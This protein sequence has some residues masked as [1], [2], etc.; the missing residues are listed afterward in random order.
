VATQ[1]ITLAKI[2]G[3]AAEVVVRRLR[4]WSAARRTDLGDE[5][6]NEQWPP[7]VRRQADEFTERLRSHALAAPVI[8]FIEWV[9]PWSMGDLFAHWLTPSEG[10]PPSVVH[11]DRFEL[12]GYALPDDGR[13][14]RYLASAGLQQFKESDWYVRRLQEAVES[15]SGVTDR[16]VILVARNVVAS[17]VTDD[18]MKDSFARVP[19]WLSTVLGVG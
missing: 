13:L 7:D 16:A 4:A 6:S 18:D 19:D 8:H 1:R 3:K 10:P 12:Y 11:G 15:Y 14:A 5:Q 17:T 9:D 2:G